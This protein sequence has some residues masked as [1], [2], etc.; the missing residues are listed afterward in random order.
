MKLFNLFFNYLFM[1]NTW[2]VSAV[3]SLDE[4]NKIWWYRADILKDWE[5]LTENQKPVIVS[6]EQWKII[7]TWSL[8][9]VAIILKNLY[10]KPN[11]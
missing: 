5:K 10:E 9:K 8:D 3:I 1:N 2:I 4:G 11:N 6:L 7:T